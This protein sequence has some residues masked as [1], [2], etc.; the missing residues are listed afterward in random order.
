MFK[1]S[2]VGLGKIFGAKVFKSL[3][4]VAIQFSEFVSGSIPVVPPEQ[5]LQIS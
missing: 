3:V 5:T 1:T 4:D 2:E